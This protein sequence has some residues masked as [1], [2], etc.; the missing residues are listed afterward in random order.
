MT[1]AEA[2]PIDGV[3]YVV[4]EEDDTEYFINKISRDS[5]LIYA[6]CINHDGA[7]MEWEL[8]YDFSYDYGGAAKPAICTYL[9]DYSPDNYPEFQ[10]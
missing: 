3:Y 1:A 2:F 7:N 5:T 8:T 10:I 4:W 6:D 9:P